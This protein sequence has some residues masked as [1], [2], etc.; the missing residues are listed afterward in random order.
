MVQ[1]YKAQGS[2]SFRSFFTAGNGEDKGN[3][4]VIELA[5]LPVVV[6]LVIAKLFHW[7]TPAVSVILTQHRCI[8]NHARLGGFLCCL[9]LCFHLPWNLISAKVNP[10]FQKARR[11]SERLP[12]TSTQMHSWMH[13]K[14]R[15]CGWPYPTKRML[16]TPIYLSD[17]Y[18]PSL[19]ARGLSTGICLWS[20]RVLFA[21]LVTGSA[22][23]VPDSQ[24]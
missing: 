6:P 23:L 21:W 5:E 16:A 2:G 4:S 22:Q 10:I 14:A 11:R 3:C 12:S 18:K 9:I 15:H 19:R 7:T 20:I 17:L 13:S 8:I 24:D 1:G